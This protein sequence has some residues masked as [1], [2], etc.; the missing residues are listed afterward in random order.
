MFN[1]FKHFSKLRGFPLGGVEDLVSGRSTKGSLLNVEG[2]VPRSAVS[3]SIAERGYREEISKK[4]S[5]IVE[6]K[7]EPS[8]LQESIMQSLVSRP[9]NLIPFFKI[10]SKP[11]RRIYIS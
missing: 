9:S 2:P 7:K 5:P 10:L 6:S 1:F 11:G 4:S 8:V 3:L